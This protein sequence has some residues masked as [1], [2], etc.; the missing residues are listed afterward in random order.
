MARM[1]LKAA[2]TNAG[3]TQKAAAKEIGVSNKTLGLWEAYSRYPNTDKVAKIC[4]CYNCTYDDIQ[5]NG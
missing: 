4:E 5:W 3:K 1:T 2:R